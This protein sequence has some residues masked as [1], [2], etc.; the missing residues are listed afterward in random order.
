MSALVETENGEWNIVYYN[1]WL[2]EQAPAETF[3]E[4]TPLDTATYF[5]SLTPELL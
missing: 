5:P 4:T 1:E 2:Q 3:Y